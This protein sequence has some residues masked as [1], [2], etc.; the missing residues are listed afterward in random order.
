MARKKKTQKRV[1]FVDQIRRAVEESGLSQY[2][3]SKE[4]GI[5]QSSLSRFMSGRGILSGENLNA[6]AD[7]IGMSVTVDP[8][9]AKPVGPDMRFRENRK[10]KRKTTRR[11]A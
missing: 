1:A 3:I 5:M 9:Q 2:R 7:L 10:A 11:R 6:L 8:S 4:L